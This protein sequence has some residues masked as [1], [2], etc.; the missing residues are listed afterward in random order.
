MSAIALPACCQYG[1][2]KTSQIKS[3]NWSLFC[4]P[5]LVVLAAMGGLPEL[6]KVPEHVQVQVYVP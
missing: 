3:I 1:A 4:A 2:S 6:L 5:R